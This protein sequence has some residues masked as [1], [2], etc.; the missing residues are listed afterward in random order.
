MGANQSVSRPWGTPVQEPFTRDIVVTHMALY[1][2]AP[3]R[4]ESVQADAILALNDPS[5]GAGESNTII[6][7]PLRA[8][9]MGMPSSEFVSKLVGSLGAIRDPDPM[10]GDYP[11]VT[12]H[13]GASWNLSKLFTI[14][15]ESEDESVVERSDASKYFVVKNGYYTWRGFPGYRSTTR[16]TPREKDGRVAISTNTLF[17]TWDEVSESEAPVY[18]MLDTP[19]DMSAGD[20]ATLVRNL[21]ATPALEGIHLIKKDEVVYYK[22]P[23]P[24]A[25]TPESPYGE[26]GCANDLCAEGFLDY[27]SSID[28]DRAGKELSLLA[29]GDYQTILN[30][31]NL[32]EGKSCPGGKCDPFL[33]NLQNLRLPRPR[34][35]FRVLFAVLFLI[36]ILVG[37]YVAL[38]AGAYDYDTK[39]SQIGELVGKLA[40]VFARR[41]Q[42]GGP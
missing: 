21:P 25:P 7:I 35:L 22:E 23:E 38:L 28:T 18:M 9:N 6:L 27:Q 20:L 37:I 10:G 36:A 14:A 2:P 1:Y 39:I 29:S 13:T 41:W 5:L 17:Y 4:M 32:I 42:T 19:L 11:T 24:P 33:Q 34:D 40:G 16:T 30:R 3:I 31:P 26:G 12:I 15:V 8:T